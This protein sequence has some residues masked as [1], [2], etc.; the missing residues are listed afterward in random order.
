MPP[1]PRPR[2]N[3][4]A[5]RL[6]DLPMPLRAPFA[7]VPRVVTLGG[8]SGQSALLAAL[9]TLECD[10]TAIVS[11]ADDGGCSGKLRA[12]LGMPP[13]GDI[14]RCLGSLSTRPDLAAHFE[15]RLHGGTEEGRCVGNLV[16]A[17]MREDVGSLQHAVDWAATLLGCVGRVVPASE[18][19]GTLSVYDRVRGPLS[20][21]SNIE[22]VSAEAMI[23]TVDGPARANR[24][25]IAA[26][27]G[28]DLVF[29]GPGSFVG[30][31]L[32][33]LATGDIAAAVVASP[34]RRVLVRNLGS[35]AH[36]GALASVDPRAH[37][38]VLR[39]HLV[40]GSGGDPVVFDTLSHDPVRRDFRMR[41]DQSVECLHPLA[42][43]DGR[44]HDQTLLAAALQHHFDLRTRVT[45]PAPI[46][47]AGPEA[48]A[49]F[50][51]YLRSARARL[52]GT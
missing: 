50:A 27:A 35:E 36:D 23:V 43:D 4:P 21:E 37:E 18:E 25:A 33:V 9:R 5:M 7:G 30:S 11:I 20:G 29:F 22:R 47:E 28:A 52:F 10:V 44:H 16:L 13:P 45:T 42:S 1:T 2:Y 40:I 14:R 32:A 12:E 6:S 19:A 39:D 26:I 15:E 31:T 38:R 48:S 51:R 8:G 41:E 24:E 34:A 3:H 17:E 49:I 46:A